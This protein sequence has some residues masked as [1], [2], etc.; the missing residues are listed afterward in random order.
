MSRLKILLALLFIA[1]ILGVAAYFLFFRGST[2]SGEDS[3]NPFGDTGAGNAT[4]GSVVIPDVGV[5]VSGAGDEVAPQLWK[6]TSD[7]VALGAVA[8]A[9]KNTPQSTSSASSSPVTFDTEVRYVD[10]ASGNIYRFRLDERVL[11]RMTNQT[12]PGIQEAS[13]APDG[14]RAFLRFL[15]DETGTERFEAYSLPANGTDGYFLEPGLSDVVVTGT[16]SVLSVLPSSN[17]VVATRATLAGTNPVTA[18]SSPLSA[19]RVRAAGAGYAAFTKP[20][21]LVSGYAFSIPRTTG[22]M[23]R[24]MGPTPGL[25]VLPNPTGTNYLYSARIGNGLQM[26]LV[27]PSTLE[28]SVL[29]VATLTEKCA[30]AHASEN[31]YCAVPRSISGTLPD[32]W[33]LGVIS[34]SDRLWEIDLTSKVASLV[35]DPMQLGN[36]DIDMTALTLDAADDVLVFTNKKDGSLWL[37]DF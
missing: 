7:P 33:Y 12:L 27:S 2:P 20:S 32:D 13:W 1:L 34:T 6:I 30:W 23:T 8:F 5:P 18:F 22:E 21:A 35:F 4:P 31:I 25:S 28:T 19:L 17:G 36:V 29:P 15:S 9:V 10:R 3:G 16:S 24:V 14:S 37:Y 26:G 11:E